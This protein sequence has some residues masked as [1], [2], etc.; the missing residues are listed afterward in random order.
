MKIIG[1]LIQVLLVF[2]FGTAAVLAGVEHNYA[3]GAYFMS[4][5]VFVVVTDVENCKCHRK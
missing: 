2:I 1:E 3:K 5:A 4:F